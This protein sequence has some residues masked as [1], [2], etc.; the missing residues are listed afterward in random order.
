MGGRA[1]ECSAKVEF[2]PRRGGSGCPRIF[3]DDR[4][5]FEAQA[6][7]T[8]DILRHCPTLKIHCESRTGGTDKLAYI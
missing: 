3:R 4:F 1:D 5:A 7:S 6:A 8:E 2:G